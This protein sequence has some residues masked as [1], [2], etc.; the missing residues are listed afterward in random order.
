V[1]LAAVL[2]VLAPLVGAIIE[3]VIMRGLTDAPETV[4]V[5][6]SISLLVALLG[7]GL[8][9]WSPQEA[10]P[11]VPFW[12]HESIDIGGWF[13]WLPGADDSMRII[14]NYHQ[15]TALAGA[16]LLALRVRR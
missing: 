7:L 16:A 8:W 12:G 5:V 10:P 3:V 1:A 11:V 13:A 15:I 6:V 2:L 14:V 4:R 9:S